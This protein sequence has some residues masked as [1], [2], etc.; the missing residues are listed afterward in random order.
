MSDDK[1]IDRRRFFR[2]GLRHLLRPLADSIE[3]VEQVMKKIGEMDQSAG[4]SARTVPLPQFWL[5]PPGA[6]PE[7]SFRQTCSRCGDCVSVCPAQCIHL[8]DTDGKGHGVPYIDA[9]AMP[10]VVCEGL[11]CMQAC[12][13][14][15]IQ[16]TA[17]IDV[18][19]GTAV[20]KEQTCLRSSGEDC[21]ICVE[22]CPVGSFALDIQ[23]GRV[24]VKPLGCIGCGVCQHDC[25]TSPKSIVVIARAARD[26][27][28]AP[29]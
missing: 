22:H 11:Q 17:L 1:P 18:K 21:R 2:E 5:R 15:A 12:P 16:Q 7:L 24:V 25:P 9:D 8:D 3:P 23:D 20:W 4:R 26:L 28:S 14:G 13:T 19:M 10:C 29:S 6:L 27:A